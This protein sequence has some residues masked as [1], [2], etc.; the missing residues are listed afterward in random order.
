MR[1]RGGFT[2]AELLVAST[3]LTIVLT[4]VYVGFNSLVSLWRLG[5]ENLPAYQDIRIA[6]G[7]L[8]RDLNGLVPGSWHLV[9]ADGR[10]MQ[11]YTVSR[12]LD[13]ETG[14]EPR[15][16]QVE[17]RLRP[18][19]G[20]RFYRLERAERPVLGPLPLTGAAA[21][22]DPE[23]VDV[24]LGTE[25][26]FVIARNMR[27]LA[28]TFLYMPPGAAAGIDAET[29]PPMNDPLERDT[30]DE[31]WGMPQGIRIALSVR[32]TAADN[33]VAEFV[34]Q[35]TFVNAPVVAEAIG[36]GAGEDGA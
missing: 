24:E 14:T 20:T 16:L 21:T 27:D 13:V 30:P 35:L 26:R 23:D 34:T 2:L 36:R 19:T 22:E 29:P 18:E 9:E 11:F 10:R 5:E 1:R 4:A 28:F 8:Q 17:Y 32:D 33:G 12:P 25:E 7:L 31:D 3:I 6:N 15:V